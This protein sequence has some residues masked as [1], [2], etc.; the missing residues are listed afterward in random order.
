MQRAFV[1]FW[2][3]RSSRF[4]GDQLFPDWNALFSSRYAFN[5][6]I[7]LYSFNG[8]NLLTDST[9]WVSGLG[10]HWPRHL[11]AFYRMDMFSRLSEHYK[12]QLFKGDEQL[13][14]DNHQILCQGVPFAAIMTSTI[15][16]NKDDYSSNFKWQYFPGNHWENHWKIAC[17]FMFVKNKFA[18][19]AL[20]KNGYD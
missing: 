8:R 6:A 5:P 18:E 20:N 11:D 12:F 13:S 1:L 15:W 9:W 17:T 4:Q 10:V 16:V 2:V 3:P 14:L 7:P 19:E